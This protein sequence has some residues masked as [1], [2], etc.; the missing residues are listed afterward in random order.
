MA[1]LQRVCEVET[2]RPTL[3]P[4][5]ILCP[6]FRVKAVICIVPFIIHTSIWGFE[7]HQEPQSSYLAYRAKPHVSKLMKGVLC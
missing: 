4:L 7:C 3:S 2:D 6:E 1:P 5:H